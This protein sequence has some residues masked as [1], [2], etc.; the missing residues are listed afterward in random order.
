MGDVIKRAVKSLQFDRKWVLDAGVD[1]L[2]CRICVSNLIF[3]TY[4]IAYVGEVQGR[5]S[6][7]LR[8]GLVG[9]ARPAP[10]DVM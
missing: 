7:E 1:S 2:E 3:T 8:S 6:C 5:G 4:S 10:T 9:V